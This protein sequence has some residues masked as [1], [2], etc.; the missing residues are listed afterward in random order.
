[1]ASQLL[2]NS[3]TLA[4]K[5]WPVARSR[6]ASES[7]PAKPAVRCFSSLGELPFPFQ[8]LLKQR[9][10][11]DFLLGASWFRN[12]AKTALESGAGLRIYAAEES[13]SSGQALAMLLLRAP[14]GQDGS[15]FH[16]KRLPCRS[17]AGLTN[18]QSIRFG[19]V[20]DETASNPLAGVEALARRIASEK[21][22][23]T[24]LDLSYLDGPP[25]WREHFARALHACGWAV[26][27]YTHSKVA[28]E[29][30]SVSSWDEF[31]RSRSKG[32][33]KQLRNRES[34]LARAGEV[35]FELFKSGG[36]ELE[37]GLADYDEIDRGCWKK[38]EMNSDFVPGLARAAAKQGA[39]RLG[40]LYLNGEPAAAE[41][42][43]L[44]GGVA[45]SL[46][47]H[48]K[49]KFAD[50]S[51]GQIAM[52]RILRHLMD[53]DGITEFDLGHGFSD[54]KKRWATKI[55]DLHGIAAFNLKTW[56]GVLM[57]ARFRMRQ[58]A[59]S[60]RKLAKRLLKR[61]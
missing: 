33:R 41:F 10:S 8:Q 3:R 18:F 24:M 49:S 13:G 4:S 21:P 42:W 56:G 1:M 11:S 44:S 57:S 58:A 54:Y 30:D 53:R 32:F 35:R 45:S 36:P 51:V 25:V 52:S 20:V 46:K 29:T 14:A 40:I 43:I 19:L 60:L 48:Y 27:T 28:F 9:D 26:R 7:I 12:L 23:W 55:R 37:R 16:G 2:T 47:G 38:A 34:R 59:L 22:G 39:L 61:G 5:D 6:T 15:I 17:L 31:L 50:K